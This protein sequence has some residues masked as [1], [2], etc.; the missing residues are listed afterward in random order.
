MTFTHDRPYK[1]DGFPVSRQELLDQGTIIS[2]EAVTD[3]RVATKILTDEG[4]EVT[5]MQIGTPISELSGRAGSPG[6]DRFSRI[7]A[8]WGYD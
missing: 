8:S 2:G 7:A 3:A 4:R 6:F 5:M 1:I